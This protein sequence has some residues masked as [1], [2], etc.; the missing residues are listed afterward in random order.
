[1]AST[2]VINNDSFSAKGFHSGGSARSDSI[3]TVVDNYLPILSFNSTGFNALKAEFIKTLIL[4][5]GVFVCALQEHFILKDNLYKLECFDT[6][7]T[8]SVPA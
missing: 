5:H 1:M 2:S 8:F 6:F 3:H 4:T 7:E